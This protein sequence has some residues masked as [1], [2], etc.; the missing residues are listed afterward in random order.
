MRVASGAWHG[1][2]EKGHK[3]DWLW[4]GSR[5]LALLS[6]AG[7]GFVLWS[8]YQAQR[9]QVTS[10]QL[11]AGLVLMATLLTVVFIAFGFVDESDSGD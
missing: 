9:D 2:M 7:L 3:I 4:A 8:D 11:V 6:I 1:V 10:D 5:A